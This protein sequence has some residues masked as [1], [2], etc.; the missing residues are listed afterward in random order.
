MHMSIC[1]FPLK[2]GSEIL[3]PIGSLIDKQCMQGRVRIPLTFVI[4]CTLMSISCIAK[5]AVLSE[6]QLSVL[7]RQCAS[8]S[9]PTV[10]R[11]VARVESHFDPFALHNDTKRI[12]VAALS[13]AAGAEQAKQW[14]SRG[15]SV[16]IGL[17][18]INSGNLS[19]LGMTVEDALDPCR[20]LEAGASILSAAYAQG[21]T[22]ADRQAALLIALSRYNTG[23]PLAGIANGYANHVISAPSAALTGKRALQKAPNTPPQWNIWGTSGAEPASWIVTAEEPSDIERAG[24]QTSDAR[25]EGRAPASSPAKGEPYELSAFQESE[26]SKP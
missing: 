26:S 8:S 12:S 6:Q 25:N 14:I 3:P 15:Y 23:N 17:M 10:L 2:T 22:V 4:A 16:D 19:A 7:V 18:Q 1:S 11:S 24:A 21:A 13:V 9:D 20:S 5:S